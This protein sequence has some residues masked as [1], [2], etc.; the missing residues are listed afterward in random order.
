MIKKRWIMIC[1]VVVLLSGC[2]P[3]LEYDLEVIDT[4]H[5]WGGGWEVPNL[6]AFCPQG[7]EC[8]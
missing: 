5:D 3:V 4:P 6:P 7:G 1:L 8:G 2:G